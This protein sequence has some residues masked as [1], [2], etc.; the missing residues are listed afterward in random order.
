VFSADNSAMLQRSAC[1]AVTW[2]IADAEG[3]AVRA[4]GD[5]NVGLGRRLVV[6]YNV[7]Y[8]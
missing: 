5:A 2:Q 8:R 7:A 4:N 1:G 3:N 6:T